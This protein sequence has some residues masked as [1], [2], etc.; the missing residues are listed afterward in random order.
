MPTRILDNSPVLCT[1]IDQLDLQPSAPQLRHVTRHPQQSTS[2]AL[3]TNNRSPSDQPSLP[4][5]PQSHRSMGDCGPSITLLVPRC[6][7]RA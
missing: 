1:F 7:L 4:S 3:G 2:Q 5:R 6:A